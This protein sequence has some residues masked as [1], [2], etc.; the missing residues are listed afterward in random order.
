MLPWG[1]STHDLF[2][3]DQTMTYISISYTSL[4]VLTACDVVTDAVV[5]LFPCLIIFSASVPLARKLFNSAILIVMI[6]PVCVF[7][8]LRTV[9]IGDGP[10]ISRIIWLNFWAVLQCNIALLANSLFALKNRYLPSV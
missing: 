10:A 8:I 3:E 6:L 4:T 5:A 7:G 2:I 9:G 1:M